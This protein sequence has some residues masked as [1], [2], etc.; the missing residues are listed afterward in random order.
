MRVHVEG[1]KVE[2]SEVVPDMVRAKIA[3][4][5]GRGVQADGAVE[6]QLFEP[7]TRREYVKERVGADVR[8]HVVKVVVRE[9]ELEFGA[10]RKHDR[11]FV[12]QLAVPEDPLG[13]ATVRAE[14]RETCARVVHC[15]DERREGAQV[16]EFAIFAVR[17]LEPEEPG[18]V[19]GAAFP[20]RAREVVIVG[21]AVAH[22]DGGEA[23][24]VAEGRG[25]QAGVQGSVREF[26]VRAVGGLHAQVEVMA[27]ALPGLE[28]LRLNLCDKGVPGKLFE[29]VHMEDQLSHETG[30]SRG[31]GEGDEIGEAGFGREG[32]DFRE[33]EFNGDLGE[34]TAD[35]ANGGK[36][37][38]TDVGEDFANELEA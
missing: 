8:V 14:G 36:V 35:E 6:L 4:E 7:P 19:G 34:R 27:G 23:G 13:D 29:V 28:G 24:E 16:V 25:E 1:E 31:L 38:A 26:K 3:R 32:V 17:A 15:I 2:H 33:E 18:E 11:G 9:V 12:Q 37:A 30:E 22:F 21:L 5:R 20:R 10:R